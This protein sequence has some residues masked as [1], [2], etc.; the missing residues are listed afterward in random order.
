LAAIKN[1]LKSLQGVQSLGSVIKGGLDLI[2]EVCSALDGKTTEVEF[3]FGHRYG[4]IEWTWAED[5]KSATAVI[6][7]ENNENHT[8]TGD[9]V[10]TSEII[11]QPTCEASGMIVYTAKVTI[12]GVEYTDTYEEEI[13]ATGHKWKAYKWFWDGY[14]SASLVLICEN[15]ITHA[16]VVKATIE[17]QTTAADCEHAGSTVYT[18]TAV[19]EGE[20]YTDVKTVEID[21]LGHD[22]NE[23]V[24]T[25]NELAEGEEYPSGA[26]ATRECKRD[27]SHK[28]T[29]DCKITV[30]EDTATTITLKATAEFD[31]GVTAEKVETFEHE[32]RLAIQLSG[33]STEGITLSWTDLEADSYELY[34]EDLSDHWNVTE[35]TYLDNVDDGVVW[36]ELRHMDTKYSYY[37]KAIKNG[38]VIAESEALDVVYNPFSDVEEG[39]DDYIR[40]VWAYNRQII[41]GVSTTEYN[42]QGNCERMNFCIMLWKMFNKPDPGKKTPFRDLNED[43]VTANNVK[44]ITWC[45]NQKIVAGYTKTSFKPHGSIT[46]AQ[47]AIMVWKAAGRPGI[48]GMDCPYTDLDGLSKNNV[49]AI[50]WCYNMGLISSIEGDK[51]DPDASGTRALLTEMLYQF[52][53][54]AHIVG[55]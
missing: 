39:T 26:T 53:Q 5:H 32:N 48:E 27:S 11:K 20:T 49:K 12:D 7:C 44:A 17:S 10:V 54:V 50:T 33:M 6:K 37:V 38:E 45:Y 36:G 9:V 41:N 51:F 23:P 25:W 40:I 16:A 24:I 3:E 47:L 19:H 4:E 1:T 29:V 35:T 52:E 15:D 28:E 30:V 22:W 31:D 43:G 8:L 2:G 13:P 21:A 42:L 55:Y 34:R 46:R 14:E 18:A